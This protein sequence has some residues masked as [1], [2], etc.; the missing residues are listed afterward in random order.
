MTPPLDRLAGELGLR[1]EREAGAPIIVGLGDGLR[2]DDDAQALRFLA[3]SLQWR[4]DREEIRERVG[5]TG[6]VSEL[7]EGPRWDALRW[8][9]GEGPAVERLPKAARFPQAAAESPQG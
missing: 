6:P 9:A 7:L 2:F 5:F 3:Y 1:V 8:L 4:D